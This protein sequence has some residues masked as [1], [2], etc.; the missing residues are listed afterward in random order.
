MQ[1]GSLTSVTMQS[2]A[3]RESSFF[4]VVFLKSLK[5]PSLERLDQNP[6]LDQNPRRLQS[7]ACCV[8]PPAFRRM[9]FPRS[10]I[11]IVGR[12]RCHGAQCSEWCRRM[13]HITVQ[14]PAA[15]ALHSLRVV[16]FLLSK[17]AGAASSEARVRHAAFPCGSAA[18]LP[19]TDAADGGAIAQ[20]THPL[21]ARWQPRSRQL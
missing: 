4:E 19:K 20:S 12:S 8:L 2:G 11:E 9:G 5:L 7:A 21:L 13:H 10:T 1:L 18:V 16:F 15:H 17:C 6:F 14:Q 3:R